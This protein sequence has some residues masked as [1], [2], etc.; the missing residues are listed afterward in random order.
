MKCVKLEENLKIN[1][2]LLLRH[3]FPGPGLAIRIPG[4]ID[5]K[6]IS[7]LK[8]ADYIFINYLKE[9]NFTIKYGKH[10]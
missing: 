9:K 2:Y 8:E 1:K 5:K 10:L 7:I 4:I 6:K 3:P